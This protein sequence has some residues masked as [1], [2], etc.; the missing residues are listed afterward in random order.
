MTILQSIY[1]ITKDRLKIL[2]CYSAKVFAKIKEN[3]DCKVKIN[4]FRIGFLSRLHN[5]IDAE[6]NLFIDVY[7]TNRVI[8]GRAIRKDINELVGEWKDP[9]V[10]MEKS[11]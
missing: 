5:I 7:H 3:T 4:G 6:L 11:L 2:H 1:V 10:K 8:Y 9:E